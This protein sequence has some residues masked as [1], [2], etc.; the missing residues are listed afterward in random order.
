VT[1]ALATAACRSRLS[2][3]IDLALHPSDVQERPCVIGAGDPL[4]SRCDDL[5]CS[6]TAAGRSLGGALAPTALASI[7]RGASGAGLC[8]LLAV[9]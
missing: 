3:Q 4:K 5:V 9:V 7:D 1:A 6:T 8:A 2:S